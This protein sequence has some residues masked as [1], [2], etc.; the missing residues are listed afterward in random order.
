MRRTG[1][2]VWLFATSVQ[3]APRDTSWRAVHAQSLVLLGDEVRTLESQL[4]GLRSAHQESTASA[5][6]AG[7]AAEQRTARLEEQLTAAQSDIAAL[8]GELAAL[9]EE[10]VW[11]FAERRSGL[12]GTAGLSSTSGAGG[13]AERGAVTGPVAVRSIASAG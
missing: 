6:L 13:D 10:L 5:E 8:R 2:L 9:R 1:L 3:P 7:Q 12:S 11:A 4:G